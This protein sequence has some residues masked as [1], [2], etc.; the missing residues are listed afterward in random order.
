MSHIIKLAFSKKHNNMVYLCLSWILFFVLFIFITGLSHS[1]GQKWH[2][3]AWKKHTQCSPGK[4]LKKYIAQAEKSKER[5]KKYIRRRIFAP[6]PKPD[7]HYGPKA[8]EVDE[9][10]IE[11]DLKEACLSKLKDLQKTTEEIKE[12]ENITIGQHDNDAYTAHRCDRLT[13]SK[14]GTVSC[15]NTM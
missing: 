11:K 6:K 15:T 5:R 3:T 2:K 7:L 13:A 9:P 14:F 10:I 8:Q 1:T 12:I 4:T